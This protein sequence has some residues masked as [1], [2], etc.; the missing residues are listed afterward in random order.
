MELFSSDFLVVWSPYLKAL[1]LYAVLTML[2]FD[3]IEKHFIKTQTEEVDNAEKIKNIKQLKN[4]NANAILA[5]LAI[6]G[7]LV[8][9]SNAFMPQLN[10]RDY[11]DLPVVQQRI[12]QQAEQAKPIVDTMRKNDLTKEERQKRFDELVNREGVK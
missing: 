11:S 9:F 3:Q 5:A 2:A 6:S 4:F 1:F 12:E 7:L 10:K 8:I